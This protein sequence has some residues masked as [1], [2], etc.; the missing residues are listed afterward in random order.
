MI[1]YNRISFQ[2]SVA[3]TF[4]KQLISSVV[5][6]DLKIES[7]LLDTKGNS[8]NLKICNAAS[9][10]TAQNMGAIS[11]KAPELLL[12][13]KCDLKADIFSAGVTLFVMLAGY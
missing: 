1:Y 8:C 10:V 4:F 13:K 11:C 12:N 5:H 2:E 6:G 9:M 3:R 7:L